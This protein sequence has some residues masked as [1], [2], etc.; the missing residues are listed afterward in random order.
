[1]GADS[2]RVLEKYKT[3]GEI[4]MKQNIKTKN[5]FNLAQP[6]L[7]KQ[8][9]MRV[10]LTAI[11]CSAF[12]NVQA[13]PLGEQVQAGNISFERGAQSLNMNQASQKAIV[14]W[15]SFSI[16]TN[17]SVRLNQPTQGI[18][19]FRVVGSDPSQIFG[20]LTA[21]GRLFLSNPNGVLFGRS[22]HVD[23]GSLVA[24]SM[25]IGNEDFLAGRYQF[26]GDANASVVNDGFILTEDGGY[27]ALLG[28]TV[29]NNGTLQVNNGSVVLGSAQ[30]AILDVYGDGLVRVKLNGDALNAV[31]KQTGNIIADGGAIQ[32]ATN[33]RS[34]AINVDGLVQANSLVERNGMIRLEGGKN[35]RVSV[36]GSLSA[37]GNAVGSNGGYI[38]V[39]GEQVALF[40]GA[41][42][43][44]SGD[45][46]GGSVLV[47]GDLQGKNYDVY[48]ARTTYVDKDANINVDA[49]QNG[50]GGKAIIWADDT[51]RYYGAISSQGGMLAGNGGFI[52]VSGK[53]NLDFFGKVDLSAS[54]GVG[55]RFLLDPTNIIFNTTTQTNPTNNPNTTPDIAFGDAATNV[56]VAGTT[57]IQI[58]DIVGFS[59]A[60]FQ[61]SNDITIA[62]TLTMGIN[63][64]IRLEANNNIN[65]NAALTTSGTGNINLR[66]DANNSGI[67]NL[68]IGGN[69][70]SRQGGVTLSA[71]TIT[72][73][74]G[75]ISATG[76]ANANAGS[77]NIISTGTTNLGAATIEANGGTASANSGRNGGIITINANGFTG[78]GVISASGSIGNGVDTNGGNAGSVSITSTNGIVRGVAVI[79]SNG[80]N[81]GTT[82]NGNSGSAGAINL[83]N[84]IA[85]NIITGALNSRVGVAIGTGTGGAAGSITI[86][87]NGIGTLATGAIT[88]AGNNFSN[89]NGG[90]V[91][92][93]TSVGNL[94]T[95]AISTSG[96]SVRAGNEGRNAGNITVNSGGSYN[97]ITIAASGSAGSGTNQSGGNAANITINANNG[98]TTTAIAASGGNATATN[99]NG[100]NAGVITLTNNSTANIN[101]TT[102]TARNGNATGTGTGANAGSITVN[103][104]A[105]GGTVT[106]TTLSTQGGTKG[107]GGNINVAS[108]GNTTINGTINS[109]GGTS[110]TGNAGRNAGSVNVSSGANVVVG[111]ITSSGSAGLGTN[112]NGGAGA[113]VALVAGV[114]N[115]ITHNNITTSGGA[116]TGTG[117]GGNGGNINVNVNALLSASTML[118]SSV[119]TGGVSSGN[120]T[121]GGTINSSGANRTLAINTTAATTLNGTIGNTLA[122]TSITTNAGGATAINGG[123]VTTTGP[124]T[125][126]D[127]VTLGAATSLATTNSTITFANS[128]NASGN[129]LTMAIGTGNITATNASNNFANVA[130]TSANNVS[131]RDANAIQLGTS[132]VTGT[133]TLQTAGAV[134]QSG[135]LAVGGAASINAGA[136]NDVTLNNVG[137]NFNAIAVVSGR[138]FNVVDSNALS[139]GTSNVRSLTARTL[140]NDLTLAG[141]I[142]ASGTG[143]GT[144]VTLA[145]AQNFINSSNSNITAG[146]GSRWLVYSSNPANDASGASLL[147]ASDF[148]QYNTAFGGSILGTG[149]GFIYTLA[150]Q[151]TASLGGSATKTYDATI[152]API[153]LLT[154]AHSGEIDGDVATLAPLTSATYDNINAGV[155]KNVTS[156][157]LSIATSTNG[158]KQVFGY[159]LATPTVTATLGTIDQRPITVTAN[160][161]QSKVFGAADPLP[162]TFTVGGLGLVGA[163]T[164]AG[165]LDRAAG[166]LA[167]SY[168]IN[169][170]SLAASNN[171]LLSYVGND[172]N[173]FAPPPNAIG[174]NPRNAAGLVDLNPSLSNYTNQQLYVL[175]VGATAAGADS[176]GDAACEQYP[177]SLAKDKEF[178]LMLNYGLNLPKG[179]NASCEKT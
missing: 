78:T 44:A 51:T 81:A 56:P 172:F 91:Q 18:A 178:I 12:G 101:T 114:A 71:A 128:V 46:G 76:A 143:A 102:T 166:E 145:S 25:R 68:A 98:I 121:F 22:A 64:S 96:G 32:L 118:T 164:L 170:G 142:T 126:N 9:R 74:A 63:N 34:A 38:E 129:T 168:A 105:V 109:A 27:I 110:L 16:A 15:Q 5:M 169:Q 42:L 125:Y 89:G 148:K 150:P 23:V 45:V 159:T 66:A 162:F 103:N 59:E 154:L 147:V 79:S 127:A 113:V 60:F 14:N 77:I 134:T 137:N 149:D 69:I 35:A 1:M 17:E 85:G 84:N 158:S 40:K 97:G 70:T 55:G 21:T 131:L 116:R 41:T 30:S 10:I 52:E 119:G 100:G 171:Y 139:V 8:A 173:I 106:T 4:E 29:E 2:K 50:D 157:A 90:N 47:G 26:F 107:N 176:E 108:V 92:V 82:G 95:G 144:S 53:E 3:F 133:Y 112:Q 141:N 161:G 136:G 175:N 87:N 99:G 58:S 104:N 93:S 49:K 140:S 31:I 75:N 111:A 167:G 123:S 6:N 7:T 36:S 94:T 43:D 117:I 151:I 179:M 57:T 177:E 122:L 115:T 80:G 120:I 165:A 28:N 20:N 62:N 153:G 48:N 67:G 155:G 88:T 174:S 37:A 13:L 19:L 65:V 54:N 152:A 24:T 135:A 73:S 86:A 163:D 124:Q 138:D 39:T 146:A 33:A 156:N 132:N 160:S 11:I 61:A 72:R 130:I 83:T